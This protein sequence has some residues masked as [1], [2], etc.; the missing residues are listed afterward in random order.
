MRPRGAIG[1]T[2]VALTI[3]TVAMLVAGAAALVLS[4]QT[5][6]PG[7]TNGTTTSTSVAL[8]S[9]SVSTA[10]VTTTGSS[11]STQETTQNSTNST[12][13]FAASS[14]S[15]SYLNSSLGLRLDLNVSVA[16]DGK[17]TV[18]GDE[19]NVLG[20]ANN[21][22]SAD[23]WPLS[24]GTLN[25][26]DECPL[27]SPVGI[28]MLNGSY[29][30]ANFTKATPLAL[31]DTNY[32]ATCTQNGP[33]T[34]FSFRPQS[35]Y[36]SALIGNY[37]TY[38]GA[39]SSSS[40]T[41]GYWTGSV[42]SGVAPEFH[43][44]V[45]GQ[46][47]TALAADEWGNSVLL[48]FRLTSSVS[49][50]S[51]SSSLCT[52]GGPGEAYVKVVSYNGPP[53]QNVTL[54]VTYTGNE[55][56]GN[57]YCGGTTF[58]IGHY[59]SS[60]GYVQISGRDGL[61]VAGEYDVQLSYDGGNYGAGVNVYNASVSTY[62]SIE[63][64][65]LSITTT[66]CRPGAACSATET[67]TSSSPSASSSATASPEVANV[68][69]PSGFSPQGQPGFE[70]SSVTVVI[71]VNDTV[72]WTDDSYL[73]VTVTS[74]STSGCDQNFD[75]GMLRR[76]QTF[77]FTFTVPGTYEYDSVFDEGLNGTVTVL[78]GS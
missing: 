74:T 56:A 38:A 69:I 7:T 68:S 9:T 20:S 42:D 28:A 31:Y 5:G 51:I 19:F 1:T 75:S 53:V 10:Q 59:S 39:A 57:F 44:F 49:T 76:G 41:F 2:A 65:S 34:V 77:T 40:S 14:Q 73:P 6:M 32:I 64:P 4:R 21:V 29:S 70:P 8:G 71:G 22:T 35:D 11:P 3:A 67:E 43:A 30:E 27:G 48:G 24:S 13:A 78:E 36:A 12:S 45:A 62:F 23:R 15:D 60:Q 16:Q 17:V 72:T 61:P 58:E 50:S 52:D 63:L 47:Y 54:T 18:Q 46:T 33:I 25:P 26:D 37:T 55:V 66:T